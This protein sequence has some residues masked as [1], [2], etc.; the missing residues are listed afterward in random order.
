VHL[1][2]TSSP[3]L[4]SPLPPHQSSYHLYLLT[5]PLPPHQSSYHL[6]LLTNPHIICHTPHSPLPYSKLQPRMS[7]GDHQSSYHLYLLTNPH[8]ICHT[9][10]SPLPYNKLQTR[11][12]LGDVA[13]YVRWPTYLSIVIQFWSHKW[14][15]LHGNG[16]C[17]PLCEVTHILVNCNPTL[18]T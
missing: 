2:S 9:P 11:M 8:I 17:H 13:R 1:T 12:S 10:H 5:N 16:W 3:I 6:Y 14:W 18:I 7:L 15:Y 4:I